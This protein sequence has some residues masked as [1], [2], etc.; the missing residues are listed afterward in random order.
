MASGLV[1]RSASKSSL[2]AT[3]SDTLSVSSVKKALMKSSTTLLGL[4]PAV[5][6]EQYYLQ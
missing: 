2:A 6:V 4:C 1:Y 3:S 5:S